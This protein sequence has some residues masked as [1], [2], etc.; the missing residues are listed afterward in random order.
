MNKFDLIKEVNRLDIIIKGGRT[1]GRPV[2]YENKDYFFTANFHPKELKNLIL[3][4][5]Q[6]IIIWCKENNR[7]INSALL[8]Y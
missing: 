7:N 4:N 8:G 2:I 3:Q 6:K 5:K 1:I